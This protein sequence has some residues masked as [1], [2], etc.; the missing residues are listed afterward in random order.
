MA[1]WLKALIALGLL[2]ALGL[3]VD[4]Q[5]VPGQ[6]AALDWR[7]GALGIAVIALELP[8]NAS[9]WSWS[10]KLHRLAFPWGYLF[11]TGCFGFFFNHFLPSAIG[12][13][14]YRV[15]RTLPPD[16]E[17]SR[18]VSAVL[19]ERLVGLAAMLCNGAAGALLL[20]P[21]NDLA[22]VYLA[23][24]AAALVGVVLAGALVRLG[25]L[26]ALRARL[27]RIALFEPVRANLRRIAPPRPEWARLLVASFVFQFLATAVVY[28]AFAG[29]NANISIAAAAL[30]TAAAG[31]ASVLPI[32]IS[33]IGVV[34]GS[35]AGTAV[36]LGVPY[37]AAVLAAVVI[38]LQ[39]LVVGAGC[40]LFYMAERGGKIA[41]AVTGTAKLSE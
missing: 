8:V 25:G 35:I 6:L 40:G 4:W 36:A 1:R 2:G 20:A 7:L 3:G 27:G 12:G 26:D 11:R 13:D 21:A 22:R 28:L 30:V 18:A 9:K 23:L 29:V 41:P 34:E 24:M 15:Y 10:L 16:G 19:V 17:R 37:D 38:R 14:V 33:G 32:S 39:A 5:A 31:I